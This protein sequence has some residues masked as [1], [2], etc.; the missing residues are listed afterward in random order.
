MPAAVA[1]VNIAVLV[2]GALILG[3][4]SIGSVKTTWSFSAFTVLIYYAITN[5]AAL[6]LSKEHRLYPRALAWCGL[7]GCL[8]LACWVEWKIWIVGLGIIGAGLLWHA[9]ARRYRVSQ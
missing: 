8:V 1:N 2:V 6:Q 9:L 3:L 7:F 4:A 5:L